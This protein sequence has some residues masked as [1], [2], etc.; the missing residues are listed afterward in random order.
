[1]VLQ[2]KIAFY[3]TATWDGYRKRSEDKSAISLPRLAEIARE[4]GGDQHHFRFIQLPF[5]L[6]MSEAATLANQ[7]VDGGLT[8]VLETARRFGISVIAS[9]SLMQAR[10]SR[11]L[12]DEVAIRF[13]GLTTHAQRALEFVRTTPGISSALAGMSKTE[14]VRENVT[15]A[16]AKARHA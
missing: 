7:P 13:P 6:A 5:N 10:L 14:H 9:A 1:M 12:P 8:N 11:N 2:G 16:V 15:I 3:G 4:A